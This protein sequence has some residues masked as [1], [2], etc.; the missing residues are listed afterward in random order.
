MVGFETNNNLD[1]LIEKTS[2]SNRTFD[3]VS[4][5]VDGLDYNIFKAFTKSNLYRS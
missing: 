2:F 3:F 5:D 1:T 4:I